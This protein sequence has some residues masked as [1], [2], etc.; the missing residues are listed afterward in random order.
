MIE[1]FSSIEAAASAVGYGE[2]TLEKWRKRKR[3]IV[4]K[5]L[6]NVSGLTGVPVKELIG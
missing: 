2:E 6:I 4:L 1:K 5:V 3:R